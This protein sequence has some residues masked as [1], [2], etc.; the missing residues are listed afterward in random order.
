MTCKHCVKFHPPLINPYESDLNYISQTPNASLAWFT[1][2]AF[3]RAG[4]ISR[5]RF[6]SVK[7][8]KVVFQPATQLEALKCGVEE[9][10]AQ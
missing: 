9:C 4:G 10:V 1:N 8:N 3:T 7:E 5:S 6:I 2:P